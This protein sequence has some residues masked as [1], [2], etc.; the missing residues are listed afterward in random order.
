M[1][2]DSLLLNRGGGITFRKA[3]SPQY[4]NTAALC[5]GIGGAG[6]K[7]LSRLRGMVYRDLIPDD[8][9]EASV[10][11]GIRFLGIDWSDFESNCELGSCRLREDEFFSLR[12]TTP[13]N[14]QE[15]RSDPRMNWIDIGVIND[16]IRSGRY[17]TEV[18]QLARFL[19]MSKAEQLYETLRKEMHAA[20]Q[21]RITPRVDVH[22]FAGLSGGTGSGC[23]LDTCYLVQKAAEEHGYDVTISGC[24]FM[25]DVMTGKPEIASKPASVQHINA[26]GFATLKE[27]NYLMNLRDA[28]DWFEQYYGEGLQVRTQ[29]P[30]VHMC[31]MITACNPDGS[32]RMDGFAD[33]IQTAADYVMNYLTMYECDESDDRN[34]LRWVC[35][36]TDRAVM[37]IP[38]QWGANLCYHSLGASSVE[39]PVKQF[40]TY[41]TVAYFREF[42][43]L[44]RKPSEEITR[45]VVDKWMEQMRIRPVDIYGRVING[46]LELNLPDIPVGAPSI[47]LTI[48]AGL[49]RIWADHE[50][51]W[52]NYCD[53]QMTR[54]VNGLTKPLDGF[55]YERINDGSLIGRL[56]RY[57][58]R[59]CV[60]PNYGPYY[61]S[62]LLSNHGNDL[63]SALADAIAAAVGEEEACRNRLPILQVRVVELKRKL[64]ERSNSKSAYEAYC[65]GVEHWLNMDM[66][67]HQWH[68]TA[69]TLRIFQTQMEELERSFFQPLIKTLENLMETFG[70]NDCYVSAAKMER[71]SDHTLL[72]QTLEE[73]KP[74]LDAALDKLG[75]EQIVCD[76]LRA[77]LANPDVWLK[78]DED[79]LV[80]LVS[81]HMCRTFP[82]EA[83]CSLEHY[84][85]ETAPKGADNLSGVVQKDIFPRIW[86]MAAPAYRHEVETYDHGFLRFPGGGS[87]VTAAFENCCLD[88][89]CRPLPQLHS[90]DRITVFRLASGLPLFVFHGIGE[91]RRAYEAEGETIFGCGVHLY[92]ENQQGGSQD[93]RYYLPDPVP[94]SYRRQ[95]PRF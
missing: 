86:D 67:V 85:R 32:I 48:K 23:Y 64:M 44:A 75:V 18:R 6:I 54:N 55:A 59:M 50:N 60:D 43:K 27:L 9:E 66:A 62:Y 25:P 29:E 36:H 2:Y 24:F 56:F 31:H 93:W 95:H 4:S 21:A 5:I 82:G 91:M 74:G 15:V 13:P 80:Q 14:T 89:P 71:G 22:L 33:A 68:K 11:G 94:Y 79:K 7:A 17:V 38:R 41:L 35:A 49:P 77:L 39:I 3:K 1:K 20:A 47:L 42:A 16:T 69:E 30:P 19:L 78:E 90:R 61:A 46:T 73:A 53:E 65:D 72:L 81:D 28:H 63:Y 52:A 26:N 51:G 76:F 88:K 8:S 10:F 12:R 45:E 58:W 84:L 57:L 37:G 92:S 87:A 34:N 83:D 70:Q 40:H